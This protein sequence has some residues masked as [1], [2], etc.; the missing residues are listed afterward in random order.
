ML[1]F[2]RLQD[3]LVSCA[4]ERQQLPNFHVGIKEE[5][6]AEH[7]LPKDFRRQAGYKNAQKSLESVF[8][9]SGGDVP[10]CQ[11]QEFADILA[12]LDTLGQTGS[13]L[14]VLSLCLSLD[15]TLK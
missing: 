15:A 8:V 1:P 4:R 10:A 11:D 13:H 9:L 6:S 14:G 5:T 7:G 3:C 2:Q 12:C